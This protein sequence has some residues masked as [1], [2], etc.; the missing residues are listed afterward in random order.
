MSLHLKTLRTICAALACAAL[1]AH[2]LQAAETVCARVVIQ[3]EQELTLEREGFEARLGIT[4]GLPV[5]LNSFEVTLKFWDATG[6]QVNV[7]TDPAYVPVPSDPDSAKF[8]YRVQEGYTLPGAVAPG[9]D[10]KVAYLIVPAIG[11]AGD[12]A[13]GARYQIGA[14]IRYTPVGGTQEIVE[15]APDEITVRPMPDL[16][17]QYFLPGDVFGDDP[18]TTDVTEP[19]EPF[20]LGVRIVN[21]SS[22]ATANRV[23]IQSGQPEITENDQGLLI[24][25]RIVGSSVNGLPAAPTLL[26]DFGNIAPLTSGM[27]HWVMTTSLSGKFVRFSAEIAHAPEFGGAL[28]SLIQETPSTHRLLGQVVVDLPDRDLVPDFLATDPMVGAFS[29]VNLYESDNA[30]VRVETTYFPPGSSGV[31][32]TSLGGDNYNLTI[33]A[34]AE[35]GYV[36]IASPL[37]ALKQ[38][39]AVRTS[40]G[41][42]LPAGNAWVSRTRT[43]AEGDI[44]HWLNL[45]DTTITAGESYTLTFTDPAQTNRSPSLILSGQEFRVRPGSMLAISATATDPD[46]TLPM[47]STG[48]L[49]DGASFTDALTGQGSFAWTPTTD[50]LGTYTIL[51]RASD[52]QLSTTQ[53]AQVTVDA[54]AT[55]GYEAWQETHWPGITDPT[56]IGSAADP[57]R[58]GL[59]NL[60]EYALDSVPTV[61]DETVLPVLGLVEIEGQSYLTLAYTHRTDDPSLTFEVV[62]SEALH[63]PLTSW[64]AQTTEV[65]ASEPA[66]ERRSVKI[67]DSVPVETGG[68]H[69]YL[70]LRITREETP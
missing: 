46:G 13:S 24:D 42:V 17:L 58:D 35:F 64:M 6:K 7:T 22:F 19:V 48:T 45:F 41:K 65:E 33:P 51:F 16:R 18:L 20:A 31:G 54:T 15:L 34:A 59:D 25:F 21:H 32:L 56:I 26:T 63:A 8:F 60:L 38:V 67:R 55:T 3:I 66:P 52:G 30:D 1:C 39:R 23:K 14:T 44:S 9:A 47:L 70:R 68:A 29:V 2:A 28:T 43:L 27:G 62:A 36:R 11:A 61:A 53:S 57:D 40:D 10:Q 12:T 37:S 49:P 50:Q 5:D 69:R 4:N